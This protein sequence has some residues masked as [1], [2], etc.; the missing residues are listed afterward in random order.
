MPIGFGQGGPAARNNLSGIFGGASQWLPSRINGMMAAS[1]MNGTLM[2]DAGS[3]EKIRKLEGLTQRYEALLDTP[4]ATGDVLAG[5]TSN[6]YEYKDPTAEGAGPGKYSGPM[7]D[8]LAAIPGVVQPGAD[9]MDRVDPGRLA[10]S[11][12][13]VVGE[14]VRS[15][16]EKSQRIAEMNAKL[17]ALMGGDSDE[18]TLRRANPGAYR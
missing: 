3:K 18:E 1:P 13:P 4:P 5:T 11:T 15:D 12:A 9:G 16:S 6:E 14:L 17:D 10:L 8:E 7:S 2:S